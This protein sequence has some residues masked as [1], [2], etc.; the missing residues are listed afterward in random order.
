MISDPDALQEV[1]AS[2]DGVLKLRDKLKRSSFGA[3]LGGGLFPF[4]LADAGQNLPLMHGC[5]VL[6]EVLLQL[7]KEGKFECTHIFLGKLLKASREDLDWQN[8][9]L[10]KKIVAD[11]NEVAHKGKLL[12]RGDCWKYLEAIELELVHFGI[13]NLSESFEEDR[14]GE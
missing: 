1:K 6:N 8:Y 5:S 4:A 12:P 11:R 7:A 9:A 13:V 3:F 10:I 14:S 2:W